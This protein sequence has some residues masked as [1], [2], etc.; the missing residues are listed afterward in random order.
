MRKKKDISLFS[1]IGALSFLLILI[2]GQIATGMSLSSYGFHFS[3]NR[4]SFDSEAENK[5]D[6]EDNA[7][8]KKLVISQAF[9]SVQPQ[10]NLEAN[11]LP[12]H[13]FNKS[14][15]LEFVHIFF[16]KQL[17]L[18]LQISRTYLTALLEHQIAANA[19]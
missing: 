14:I 4:T 9:F 13:F 2:L 7:T 10:Q 5:A 11:W 8:D 1:K 19:P 17:L 15:E 3:E 12:N 18:P 6:Q 16:K